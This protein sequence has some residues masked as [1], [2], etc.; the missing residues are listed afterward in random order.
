MKKG[1]TAIVQ[2]IGVPVPIAAKQN[3]Y[4]LITSIE[5]VANQKDLLY[6]ARNAMGKKLRKRNRRH[7]LQL[8]I[9]PNLFPHFQCFNKFRT[10]FNFRLMPITQ[11]YEKYT[12]YTNMFEVRQ[13]YSL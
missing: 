11:Y 7:T 13:N 12:N 8:K 2:N 6:T 5:L 1:C 4:P 3:Y 9:L 10:I